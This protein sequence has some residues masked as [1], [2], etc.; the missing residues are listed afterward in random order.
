MLQTRANPMR[1]AMPA[2]AFPED[3]CFSSLLMSSRIKQGA[4]K[5]TETRISRSTHQAT[6]LASI[7]SMRESELKK[8]DAG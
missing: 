7:V 8:T 6:C 5:I 1:D 2:M 4:E 3:A